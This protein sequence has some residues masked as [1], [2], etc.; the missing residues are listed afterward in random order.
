MILSET[1]DVWN[2][3]MFQNDYCYKIKLLGI[4]Y[5]D[6]HKEILLYSHGLYYLLDITIQFNDFLPPMN[7][8]KLFTFET[9]DDLTQYLKDTEEKETIELIREHV[10]EFVKPPYWYTTEPLFLTINLQRSP[11]EDRLETEVFLIHNVYG[12][13]RKCNINTELLV[14]GFIEDLLHTIFIL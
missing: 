8:L 9:K 1:T 6:I 5:I 12:S 4:R 2:H 11:G 14:G 3:P 13:D 10:Y 7:A